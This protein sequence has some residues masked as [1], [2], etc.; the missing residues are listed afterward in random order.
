[1]TEKSIKNYKPRLIMYGAEL[2]IALFGLIYLILAAAGIGIEVVPEGSRI[3]SGIA[4]VFLGI[5]L[6]AIELIFR[7][8]LPIMIHGIYALYIFFSN[9]IGSCIGLFRFMFTPFLWRGQLITDF[10]W[11]DKI[12]H[13]ILGYVLCVVAVYLAIKSNIWNKSIIGDILIILAISMGFAS[14]WEIFEFTCDS[15]IP[16]QDMQRGPELLDTMVDMTLHLIFTVVFIVQ[17]LLSKYTKCAFGIN[18]LVA[19]LSTGGSTRLPKI[20]DET[21]LQTGDDQQINP[22]Q[23]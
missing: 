3:S 5:G 9:V 12:M 17:Y 19:N 13:S 20:K 16:N 4:T 22:D 8:R 23:D 1:M 15:I 7:Y 21:K 10:G 2:A 18:Y 6:I 11:F 14:L